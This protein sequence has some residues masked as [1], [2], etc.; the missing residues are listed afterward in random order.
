MKINMSKNIAV[1]WIDEN[2]KQIIEISDKVWEYAELGLLEQKTSKLLAS[3]L[4]NHGFEV[5]RGVAEMPTAFIA[6]WNN[7]AGP[8]IGVLG[9]LDAL[10]GLSQ[11]TV[12]HQEPIKNGAPGHGCGHNIHCTSGMASAIAISKAMQEEN[13]SGSI[14]FY[15]CPAEETLVGKIWL[16]REGYFTNV[17]AVLAHHPGSVNTADLNSSNATNS[18]KFHFF[19]KASHAAGSPE[20]GI[21]AL[22]AVEIMSVGANFM[23][24]HLIDKARVHYITEDGGNQPNVVPAYARSW[25]YVR[26]PEREQV[27]YIY[28]WLLNVAKGADLIARTTHKIEFLTGCYNRIPNKLL[29]ELIISKM[30][31]IG[32]PRFTEEDI[33]FAKDLDRTIPRELKKETLINDGRLGYNN[34]LDDLFDER[35]LDPW[36][37][38]K[39]SAGS[40]DVSDVSWVTPTM[41]FET[42]AWTLS[43]PGHSWQVTAQMGMSIGH[44]SLLFATKVISCSGLEL[45]T[46]QNLLSMV[47]EEWTERLGGRIY[48]SP[49]PASL[50]PPLNEFKNM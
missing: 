7:G 19:G 27:E 14:V 2:E 29:S 48:K 49:I 9:E 12:S 40:T 39:T 30:R 24:E 11:K 45:L 38:G 35:I 36:K 1:N 50:K 26:A 16:V 44:K 23:R 43:S 10:P 4:E 20:Q 42:T 17:D 5:E 3:E 25:Y 18:V 8:T 47:R 28:N 33:E 13:I 22:D 21:S 46:N 31:Q 15:G 37:E 32:A 6:K 34:M 41:E